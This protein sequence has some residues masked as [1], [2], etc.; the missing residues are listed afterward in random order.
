MELYEATPLSD[1]E[2][3]ALEQQYSG[4]YN[5]WTGG[6]LHISTKSR[7]DLSYLAMRLSGYN[8]CPTQ[9]TYKALFQ[10]MCYLYHHPM[11]PIMFARTPV[12]DDV[13]MQSHFGKGSAEI[14]NYDYSKHTGLESWSDADFSRDV[15]SRRST[16]SAEHTYNSVSFAWTCTK[17]PEPGGSVNEAETRA[18]F[19][20]TRKTI[21]YRS[22]LQ[23]LHIPQHHPTPTFEDNQATIAQVLNDRLTPRI[24]H[25][26]VL[27]AWLNDQFLRERFTPVRCHTSNN[28]ADK[29]TKPHGGKTLQ[30]MH[31]R[32]NGFQFYPPAGSEH[33]QLL[34][35]DLFDI[36]THRGSFLPNGQLPPM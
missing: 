3:Q 27:V 29:N 21:W 33:H 20:T 7:S 19:Q 32:T 18:L 30:T 6:L 12:Q 16:T 10:G 25:I 23:S 15:L 26:D 1:A 36:G 9:A 2:L 17:Q 22:I 24:R 13:P 35:L 11:V 34:Q 31:L 14:T 4:P 5:H 28:N 8:N